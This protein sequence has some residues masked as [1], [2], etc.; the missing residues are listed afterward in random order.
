MQDLLSMGV[1]KDHYYPPEFGLNL[2]TSFFA[3]QD[4]KGMRLKTFRFSFSLPAAEGS[5]WRGG[6]DGKIKF[7]IFFRNLVLVTMILVQGVVHFVTLGQELP[8][9][10][11]AVTQAHRLI[12]KEIRA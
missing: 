9:T 10:Y 7:P 12:L 5:E 11:Q 4:Q 6:D 3:G 8:W 1:D 2:D